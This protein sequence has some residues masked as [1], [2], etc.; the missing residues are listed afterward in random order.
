M[1]LSAAM[2]AGLEAAG[3]TFSDT[4]DVT[5]AAARAAFGDRVVEVAPPEGMVM[6]SHTPTKPA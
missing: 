4:T 5:I 3:H 6:A 1:T 2:K